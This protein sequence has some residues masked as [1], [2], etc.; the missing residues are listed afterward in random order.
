[1]AKDCLN[2]V[3]F[4]TCCITNTY[5][6]TKILYNTKFL[7]EACTPTTRTNL[8]WASLDVMPSRI[9]S[10]LATIRY[11]PRPGMLLNLT[12]TKPFHHTKKAVG[13]F[14]LTLL[15]CDSLTL[16][17]NLLMFFKRNYLPHSLEN[18]LQQ[19][20]R[21][22]NTVFTVQ[23]WGLPGVKINILPHTVPMSTEVSLGEVSKV[24]LQ[25]KMP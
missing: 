15:S 7:G 9:S 4:A 20:W 23:L 8:T 14:A 25:Q 17:T 22:Y 21:P 18:L 6:K 16:L 11:K 1:M 19:R 5:F 12:A 3:L 24:Q 10:M 2:S 13:T